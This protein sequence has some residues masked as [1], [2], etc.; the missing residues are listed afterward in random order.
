MGFTRDEYQSLIDEF[1]KDIKAQLEK[2]VKSLLLVGSVVDNVHIAGESDCDF[3]V[4]I[5]EK[6]AAKDK[7]EKTIS[8]LGKIISKYL[9]D[10]LFASL[11]D[12]KVLESSSISSLPATQ[13][14]FAQKGRELI[15]K[16]PFSALKVT[17]DAIK[18][19]ARAM[20]TEFYNQMKDLVL[21]PPEDEYQAIYMTVDAVLGCAC[22][23]MYYNGETEFYR[24]N[25]QDLIKEKYA[26]KLPSEV[27]HTCFKLRLGSQKVDKSNLISEALTFCQEANKAMSK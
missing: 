12:V 2:E 5:D 23:F 10:P 18:E 6:F 22:A 17:E 4:I 20:G 3:L 11:I 25:V 16:N 9:E 21:Y 27:V 15:G 24:S 1:S 7:W 26:D 13:I 8:K 14:L 19:S